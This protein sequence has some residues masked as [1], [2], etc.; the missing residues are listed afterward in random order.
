MRLSS[1][2]SKC[3]L[4][5]SSDGDSTNICCSTVSDFLGSLSMQGNSIFINMSSACSSSSW[6]LA[7]L[8]QESRHTGVASG[9]AGD[10]CP[11]FSCSP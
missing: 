11:N 8:Q 3:I 7:I 5:T 10:R 1:T 2:L 6:L 4:T 9:L